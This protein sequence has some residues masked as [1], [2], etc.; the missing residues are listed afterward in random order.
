MLGEPLCL[1]CG[2]ILKNRIAKAAMSDDLGDGAGM[3]TAAQEQLYRRWAEGGVALALVGETQ[4]GPWAPE[5]YGNLVLDPMPE[6]DSFRA[7]TQ[8]AAD[9]GAHLWAQLGHAGVLA[10]EVSGPP[11]GPS[12]IDHPEIQAVEMSSEEIAALPG[13]Y[14]RA[15][16]NAKSV[17][18]TG[19][20]IHAAHGFL[21]S[22]FL[23]PLFNRRTDAWGGCAERRILLLLEVIG[24]VRAAVGPDFPVAVK[25]NATD[26]LEGG[27][28]AEESLG[29]LAKLNDTTVDLIDI[30]GGAYF[31]GAATASDSAGDGPYF[32]DFARAARRHTRI[33]L[34]SAGG[35]KERAQAEEA[36]FSGTLDVIGLARPLVVEPDLPK[37]WIAGDERAPLFPRFSHRPPGGVTA[38]YTEQIRA[39]SGLDSTDPKQP[40]TVALSAVEKRKARNREIW[41]RQFCPA[42]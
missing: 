14:A 15:A 11:K 30:S 3:P 34:M 40:L 9:H 8:S 2:A 16:A 32:L 29:I 20:E 25:I 33:P 5:T 1:P 26:Q 7:L 18:F 42:A 12:A 28:E 4:I 21:L 6:P 13:S 41:L 31:P 23:S 22:Q 38:W 36:V 24:A 27:L 39:L 35:F 19:V 17:G 37:A 10:S